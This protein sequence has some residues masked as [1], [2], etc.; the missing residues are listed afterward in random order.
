MNCRYCSEQL[1]AERAEAVEM[2][3]LPISC[4]KCSKVQAPIVL[5]SYE[6]KTGGAP[7][8][9]PNNPD[10]TSNEEMIRKA[11]RCYTRSR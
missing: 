10:G 4:I 9:I 8:V 11:L 3:D 5:M 2:F 1:D 7:M 6:H